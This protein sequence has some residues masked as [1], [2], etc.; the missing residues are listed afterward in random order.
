M[1]QRSLGKLIGKE[2]R[3]ERTP[4]QT[5][6]DWVKN[7]HTIYLKKEMGLPKPWTKDPIFLDYKFCNPFRENDK[8]TKWFRDNVRDILSMK[9]DVL[10]ATIIFRWFNYIPTGE[11]LRD[12]D[13]LINWNT[14]DAI[15]VLKDENKWVTGA[16]II[17]TPDEMNK[18]EG[19]CRCID[20]IWPHRNLLAKEIH[21]NKS[22]EWAW[23]RLMEYPYLGP[24]MSYE[25][26][27]DLR[28]TYLLEDAKDIMY[29]ANPGPG[30]KRGLNRIRGRCID[31]DSGDHN[32][33]IEMHDLL[34]VSDK[35]LPSEFP[36]LEM[37][38][39]EH[40][41]CEFDKYERIRLGQ[42]RMKNKYNGRC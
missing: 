21:V 32:F 19:I 33:I 29:W 7:R 22:L 13:L 15:D 26:V 35:Y 34:S 30:A 36:Q 38:D 23:E 17:K 10:M 4:T 37:R 9:S 39:I 16:Y 2:E 27:T 40:S 1:Q 14:V 11:I 24:F 42:G 5:F 18:L 20:Q 12:N 3:G 41:L 31:F 25:V 8:T 6:F 28:H